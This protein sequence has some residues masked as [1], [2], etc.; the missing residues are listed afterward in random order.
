MYCAEERIGRGEG[1]GWDETVIGK[2]A[3]RRRSTVVRKH[4]TVRT[5][6]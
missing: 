6:T 5:V 1:R 4:Y 3:V 2:E